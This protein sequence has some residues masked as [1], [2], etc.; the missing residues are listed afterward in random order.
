MWPNFFFDQGANIRVNNRNLLWINSW[1]ERRIPCHFWWMKSQSFLAVATVQSRKNYN[2]SQ[3]SVT[4]M[5]C[6]REWQF[7]AN[8]AILS[9]RNPVNI[10]YA[11]IEKKS[12][13]SFWSH[14]LYQ[15]KLGFFLFILWDEGS[16]LHPARQGVQQNPENYLKGNKKCLRKCV[17]PDFT[18]LFAA[19]EGGTGVGRASSAW[20]I[21]ET[22]FFWQIIGL[23]ICQIS[24][25][26]PLPPP[27]VVGVPLP[28]LVGQLEI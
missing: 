13:W 28:P 26:A 16:V 24:L 11:K 5:R 21:F 3:G 9:K 6:D 8:L 18:K 17:M 27:S 23:K 12:Y 19:A 2:K 20:D 10:V 22:L 1:K 4:T 14:C 15:L 25:R 7:V